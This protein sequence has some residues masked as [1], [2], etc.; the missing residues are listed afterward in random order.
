MNLAQ[1]LS[2]VRSRVRTESAPA[3]TLSSQSGQALTL[4]LPIIQG[5]EDALRNLL[6]EIGTHIDSNSYFRFAQL[7]SVH[8][9]RWVVVPAEAPS[10]A[11]QLAFESNH[12]GTPEEHLRELFSKAPEGMHAIYQHCVGY[13]SRTGLRTIGTGVQGAAPFISYLLDH[14]IPSRAFYVGVPGMTVKQVRG[15]AEIRRR[16]EGYL[17]PAAANGHTP[18]A[19]LRAAYDGALALIREDAELSAIL[20]QSSDAPARNLVRLA[21]GAGVGAAA[22]PALLPALFAIRFKEMFDKQTGSLAIPDAA[23]ALMAREDLQVQN[24]LTHVVPLK[25]GPLRA[26]STRT[27]LFSIDFLAREWFTRGQLGGISSIHFARWVLI[28]GGTRLLFFS[29][30]DGSWES[31]LG[32]FIDKAAVGLTAVWSNTL[33]FPKSFFLLF[34]GATDEERFKSWTRAH[35]ITTQLWYSAYPDLT[36]RNIV[37]NRA[38]CAGLRR[39]LKHNHQLRRWLARF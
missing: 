38:I 15:E 2:A 4:V 1:S 33:D 30:Y 18:R 13:P 27:V 34:K 20:D 10:A 19:D 24:Q 29:N 6:T 23:R 9:M 37:N 11:V 36:V 28:D 16:I 5:R 26:L 14:K 31:Y 8:F 32:D 35:Q 39:G 17:R 22:L 3:T 7:E 12:D 25:A 21:A